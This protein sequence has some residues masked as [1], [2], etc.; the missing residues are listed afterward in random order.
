MMVVGRHVQG[1][2]PGALIFLNPNNPLDDYDKIGHNREGLFQTYY[3]FGDEFLQRKQVLILESSVPSIT[4]TLIEPLSCIVAALRCIAD[5]V[6]GKDVLV[7]G[8]GIIGLMFIETCRKIW[9]TECI[10][11]ESFADEA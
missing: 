1:L 6:K 8:A 5:R 10:P 9:F 7:V 3:K 4:D 11:C 2:K